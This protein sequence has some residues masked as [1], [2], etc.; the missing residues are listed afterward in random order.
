MVPPSLDTGSFPSSPVTGSFSTGAMVALP[1]EPAS[2]ERGAASLLP[3]TV[4]A[5]SPEPLSLPPAQA[6]VSNASPR[7]SP[8][9]TFFRWTVKRLCDLVL[10]RFGLT[11]SRE[12]IR[13]ALK[14]LKLSWKK[15]KK[16]LSR[17]DPAQ[18]EVFVTKLK[19]LLAEAQDPN[20]LL[21]F[22]DEGHIHQDAD[23]GYGWS[24]M[25]HRLWVCSSSPGL[26]ARVS[27]YGLYLYNEGQV[28]IWPYERANGLKT[29][30]VM[31]RLRKEFPNRRIRIVWDGAAYHRSAIVSAA[32]EAMKIEPVRLPGYSP[33][34][35]PVEALWRWLREDVT[36]NHCHTT[37]EELIA[38][39]Q[40]FEAN[41]NATPLVVADRLA[42]KTEL[43]PEEEKLRIS[44]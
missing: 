30:D 6:A 41:L 44:K 42:V 5:E 28:R 11:A 22:I 19:L 15:A 9:A 13:S 34:F 20:D 10:K 23:L 32:A 29:I 2:S 12:T 35:M 40:A 17:G 8:T 1:F 26:Q 14:R 31:K 16:L 33:D 18:R 39:V 37:P 3:V 27:F 4:T 25:G 43:D 21:V 24:V 36:Y 7:V 38:R